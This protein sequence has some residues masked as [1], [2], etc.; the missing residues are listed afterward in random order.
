MEKVSWG[1]LGCSGF[2]RRRSIPAMLQS[3]STNLLAVASRTLEKAETFRNE[4]SLAQCYGSYNELLDAPDIDAVHIPL[5]NALHAEWTLKALEKGKHVLCEKSFSDNVAITEQVGSMVK[6]TGLKFMEAFVWRMHPQHLTARRLIDQGVIGAVRLVRSSF[7]FTLT[8]RPNIRMDRELGGGAI[9]DVGCYP[10]SA[11]RFYFG[12][13]PVR[14]LVSG[15]V[16]SQCD[17]DMSAGGVLEF[18]AGNAVFDCSFD[19]PFRTDLEVVGERGRIH[20]PRAWQPPEQATIMVNDEPITIEPANQY[21]LMFEHFSRCI[22][23]S[24][25]PRYDVD[26]AIAQSRTVSAVLQSIRTRQPVS[27]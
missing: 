27:L 9:L 20:F 21:Q 11:A 18:P 14:V 25:P 17:V 6:R 5:P 12:D 1:V 23:N 2:A 15:A 10:I 7:S 24:E 16:D 26:D 4:F 3:A 13:E 19:L 22:L 8:D